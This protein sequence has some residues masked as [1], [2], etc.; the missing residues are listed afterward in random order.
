VSHRA[1]VFGLVGHPVGHSISKAM[2][3]A[4]YAAVGAPH[5]YE[6]LDAPDTLALDRVVQ[7]LR[8][9]SLSGLNVT[10]PHKRDALRLADEVDATATAVGAANVLTCVAGRIVASNTDAMALARRLDARLGVRRRVACVLGAGGA[11]AAAIVALHAAGIER[12]VV[13]ARDCARAE[14]A[15]AGVLRSHDGILEW[16]GSSAEHEA[17][18]SVGELDAIVNATSAG[19]RGLEAQEPLVASIPWADLRSGAL[20]V[21]LVYRPLTTPLLAR[22]ASLGHAVEDGLGMLVG[23]AEAAFLTWL[24]RPSP[25]G[26][27]RAAALDALARG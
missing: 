26:V 20:V 13:R 4:A 22:A 19:T 21:D 10:L 3:E 14:K 9:G 7:R 16:W 5:R 6:L 2:H 12:V 8:A 25:E 27:M 11:A 17:S 18:A 23:Q 1:L 24:G 15:L